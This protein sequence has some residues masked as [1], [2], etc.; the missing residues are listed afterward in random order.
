MYDVSPVPAS[1]QAHTGDEYCTLG[2]SYCISERVPRNRKVA[3]RLWFPMKNIVTSH[4]VWCKAALS[5]LSTCRIVF[6]LLLP[7]ISSKC[8]EIKR[9]SIAFNS[10]TKCTH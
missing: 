2:P 4:V 10:R 5:G 1:Y 6:W 3:V 8:H 9:S 7:Q